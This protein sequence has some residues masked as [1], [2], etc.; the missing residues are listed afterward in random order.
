MSKP[1]IEAVKE[2]ARWLVL[3]VA[4][5][6]VTEMLTQSSAIPEFHKL[7]VWVFS[8]M[9][10]VRTAIVFGLTFVGRYLDKWMFTKTHEDP[11]VETKGFLPF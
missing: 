2:V 6:I 9:I 8:F 1:N 10:P 5:W 7:D 3:F 4:S 11:K